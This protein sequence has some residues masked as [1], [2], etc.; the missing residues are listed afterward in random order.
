MTTVV[1]GSRAAG[2]EELLAAYT[3]AETCL[4]AKFFSKDSQVIRAQGE[5][6]GEAGDY[7]QRLQDVE[8]CIRRGE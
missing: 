3:Q 6:G 7:H 4:D 5:G 1:L 2:P 8:V